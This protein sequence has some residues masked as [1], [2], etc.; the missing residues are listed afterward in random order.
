MNLSSLYWL[1]L[2]CYLISSSSYHQRDGLQS[3][4]SSGYPVFVFWFTFQGT[5]RF[6]ELPKVHLP[7]KRYFCSYFL[8]VHV[9]SDCICCPKV[10]SSP[11]TTS[12]DASSP[13]PSH[14]SNSPTITVSYYL[15]SYFI[16]IIL[17]KR[18]ASPCSHQCWTYSSCCSLNCLSCSL[19]LS[20]LS[21]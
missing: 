5:N 7:L 15:S 17:L 10:L 9:Q 11:A 6:L 18:M 12:R 13:L 8:D 1:S 16:I 19:S 20:S 21:A 2:R 4:S 14:G 3:S